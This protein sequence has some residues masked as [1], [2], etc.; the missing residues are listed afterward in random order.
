[1][2]SPSPSPLSREAP[3]TALTVSLA[4]ALVALGAA[5]L[6]HVLGPERP[7]PSSK[8]VR[9]RCY[10][11]PAEATTLASRLERAAPSGIGDEQAP[12]AQRYP[13]DFSRSGNIDSPRGGPPSRLSHH[14]VSRYA[15]GAA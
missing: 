10:S 3:A 15:V 2:N 9:T 5:L 11:L 4:I 13:A 1:M 8:A 7:V 12:F 6:G 14:S